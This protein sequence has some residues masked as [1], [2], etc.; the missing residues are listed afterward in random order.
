MPTHLQKSLRRTIKWCHL[1]H[2]KLILS[3]CYHPLGHHIGLLPCSSTRSNRC[4]RHILCFKWRHVHCYFHRWSLDQRWSLGRQ[5]SL[6]QWWDGGLGDRAWEE[7]WW[8]LGWVDKLGRRNRSAMWELADEL[9]DEGVGWQAREKKKIE[10]ERR[11]KRSQR[12]REKI[13]NVYLM[14]EEREV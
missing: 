9:R 5:W 3:H 1:H 7:R 14:R 10:E 2:P 8:G 6:D 13:G 4:H 12:E 11:K